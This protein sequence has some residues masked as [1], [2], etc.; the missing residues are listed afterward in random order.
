MNPAQLHL[1]LNH[2]PVLG[3]IF[4]ALLLLV[5]VA[6]KS[7]EIE[8]AA[9]VTLVIVAVLAIPA[10]L[11]GEPAEELVHSLPGVSTDA[12]EEHEE[13]ALPSLLALEAA[14]VA[15]LA[16]LFL[17]RRG[18]QRARRIVT[19]TLLLAIVSSGLMIWTAHLGGRIHH[20]ELRG[21]APP[22]SPQAEEEHERE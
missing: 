7:Q 20:Q 8:R 18:D 13:S 10:Y 9:L 3:T 5:A 15:A 22:A 14:A 19:L 1:W 4:A 6:R 12:V 16:G 11:S 17:G 2:I 21:E